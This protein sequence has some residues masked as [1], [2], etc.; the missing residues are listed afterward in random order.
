MKRALFVIA[1]LIAF[2]SSTALDACISAV[3]VTENDNPENYI[4]GYDACYRQ[5]PCLK[6]CNSRSLTG[7]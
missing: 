1:S 4:A 7:L 2:V 6:S 3:V 5:F